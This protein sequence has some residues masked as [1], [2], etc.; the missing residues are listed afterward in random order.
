MEG[1]CEGPDRSRGERRGGKMGSE[2][3]DG[4]DVAGRAR[5]A[6]RDGEEWILDGQKVWTAG[7]NY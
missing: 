1:G 2:R 6:D 4:A 7:A 3:G 5:R